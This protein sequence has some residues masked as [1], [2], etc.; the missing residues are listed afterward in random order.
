[1]LAFLSPDWSCTQRQPTLMGH[2]RPCFTAVLH[3]S[4][5]QGPSP[6]GCPHQSML[7][8]WVQCLAVGPAPPSFPCL[9]LCSYCFCDLIFTCCFGSCITHSWLMALDPELAKPLGFCSDMRCYSASSLLLFLGSGLCSKT[10]PSIC[11]E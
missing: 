9:D 3:M 10:S 5:F 8:V 6:P 7:Y 2:Q 4:W 11:P 1:M